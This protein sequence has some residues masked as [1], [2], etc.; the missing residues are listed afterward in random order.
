MK[1]NLSE[2]VKFDELD[3]ERQYLNSNTK[4]IYGVLSHKKMGY[5]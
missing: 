4:K 2:K 3:R 1:L 5:F